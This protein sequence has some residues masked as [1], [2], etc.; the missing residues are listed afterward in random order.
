MKYKFRK[1]NPSELNTRYSLV[2]VGTVLLCIAVFALVQ[3]VFMQDIFM[4]NAKRNMADA[5]EKI[6]AIDYTKKGFGKIIADIEGNGNL[7]IEIYKPRDTLIYTTNSNQ[8]I[9][10]DNKGNIINVD[11]LK[12]RIMKIL[13]RL[14]FEEDSYYEIRQE[15]YATAKYLVY[16][17]FFGEDMS[18]E[19]F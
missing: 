4:L 9:Y 16:G 3:F 2:S 18:V 12:P 19:I 7:Y 11:E 10:N 1:K 13:E 5:A 8:A 15:Y 17:Y 6:A 14:E